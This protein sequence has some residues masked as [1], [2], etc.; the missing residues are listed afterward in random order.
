MLDFL[1][2]QGLGE[3]TDVLLIDKALC[4]NCDNC[5]VA[6]AH[7]MMERRVSTDKPVRFSRRFVPAFNRAAI[8][9]IL[10]A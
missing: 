10:I 6:C 7:A 3:A 9:K 4:V 2:N 5:E 1:L 8:A